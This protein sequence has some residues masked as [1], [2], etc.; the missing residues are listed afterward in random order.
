MLPFGLGLIE[1]LTSISIRTTPHLQAQDPPR[2]LRLGVVQEERE[3]PR[4]KNRSK[5]IDETRQHLTFK[6]LHWH[7]SGDHKQPSIP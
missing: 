3:N 7:V 2:E 5:E 1:T 4:T 6:D